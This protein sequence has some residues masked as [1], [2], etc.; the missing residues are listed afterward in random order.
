V[1]SSLNKRGEHRPPLWTNPQTDD[2]DDFDGRPTIRCHIF[3]H[4]PIPKTSTKAVTSHQKFSVTPDSYSPHHSITAMSSASP[5]VA[6]ATAPARPATPVTNGTSG[7]PAPDAT[8]AGG[9]ASNGH[10]NRPAPAPPASAPGKK[11]KQKKAPEPNEASKL[12]AQRISQL[13]LDAAGEKDQEAEI[14]AFSTP[15]FAV[16]GGRF[17]DSVSGMPLSAGNCA[18]TWITR[19]AVR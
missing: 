17:G 7:A 3:A 15:P 12:I 6:A 14:G 2:L 4:V 1:L 10:D 16:P 8:P 9:H 18:R 5:N 11:G 19:G 13:E